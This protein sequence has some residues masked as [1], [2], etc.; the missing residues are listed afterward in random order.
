MI[1]ISRV[2][3]AVLKYFDRCL[4]GSLHWICS[5]EADWF[6][7][8]YFLMKICSFYQKVGV[9]NNSGYFT[10]SIFFF[11]IQNKKGKAWCNSLSSKTC[12][13]PLSIQCPSQYC[14]PAA[15]RLMTT[16]RFCSAACVGL[17]LPVPS[18]HLLLVSKCHRCGKALGTAVSAFAWQRLS[19]EVPA[20]HHHSQHNTRITLW[21]LG[22]FPDPFGWW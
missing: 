16:G 15:R 13:S 4:S 5:H 3:I 21:G 12:P 1:E 8:T 2:A 11:S 7:W 18:A 9:K 6:Q 20:L 19:C 17:Y 14:L 22:L 10:C